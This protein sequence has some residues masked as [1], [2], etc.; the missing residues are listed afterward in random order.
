MST[1]SSTYIAPGRP[2]RLG[3]HVSD[4]G[5]RFAVFSQ[6]AKAIDLCLF[7][8]DGVHEQQRYRLN[9]PDDDVFHGFIPNAESG[10]IYAY[11]AF[12]EYNPEHGHRFNDNKVLLDPYAREIVGNFDWQSEHYGAQ[13][14]HP[15]GDRYPDANDNATTAL[16]ARAIK[17][18]GAAPGLLNRPRYALENIVLYELHVKGF[19]MALPGIPDNIRGTFSALAHPVAIAHFK[20]L[21]ITTLSL[22]PVQQAIS[23]KH[24]IDQG[25]KNYWGYNLI[26]FFCP[27]P[28]LAASQCSEDIVEEFRLMVN[29]LHENGFEVV[30]DVVFNHTAE[31][32][33]EGPTISMRG[34]DNN[35]WYMLS[36]DDRSQY[37]NYS[38][39]GNTLNIAHPRVCQFV[40]DV[41][42]FWV[43]CMGV[44]GFRFDLAP[45]LGRTQAGF[46]SSAAF[47]IAMR[48]DPVL[49]SVHWIAEPWDTGSAGY[50][51]GHFPGKFLEWNDRFRDTV[52]GYW[53]NKGVHRGEFARRMTGSSD[54]FHH[55]NRQPTA[56]VNFIASHDGFSLADTVSYSSKH[57]LAN[58][59]NNQD[60][61]SHEICT[62]LGV[63]GETDKPEIQIQRL[64]IRRAMLA[65]VLLAQG[66]PM[67]CAGDEFGNS[68][69]GNNN[70]YCQD[71]ATGWLDWSGLKSDHDTQQLVAQLIALRKTEPLFRHDRWFANDL[72]N[73]EQ[74]QLNWYAASGQLMQLSDWHNH[75]E[76]AFVCQLLESNCKLA[77]YCIIFNPSAEPHFF[78]LAQGPW[79][80]L[81]DSSASLINNDTKQYEQL[82]A[83]AHSLLV[84]TRYN[85]VQEIQRND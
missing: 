53:L 14:G 25:L 15:E 24:L 27:D 18:P 70:V 64:L 32:G 23:E 8:T 3:A 85:L 79:Q 58:G 65:T 10:L 71:N 21:G 72:N 45:V 83:P 40:M 61:H 59:E 50:Q 4:D 41:L 75:T 5:V 33:A 29:S 77:K 54:I 52:R 20:R 35:S 42:R 82:Y 39:C 46:D 63:E 47:F 17:H 68:Q 22:L 84:L 49:A 60:G 13:V 7:D 2:D 76:Q 19:S 43:E 37:L 9:G 48:Q 44:D 26:G 56:S 80:V 38:G 1:I 34:L 28:R 69:Q 31:S 74:A 6:N 12:G 73:T 67:L 16:K 51:L 78:Q 66:T 57:N 81:I 36:P 30:I 62:N 55:A 11:R